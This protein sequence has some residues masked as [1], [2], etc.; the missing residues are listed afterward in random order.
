M[1]SY[2]IIL[3]FRIIEDENVPNVVYWHR[4]MYVKSGTRARGNTHEKQLKIEIKMKWIEINVFAA[5]CLAARTP[6]R[7]FILFALPPTPNNT[8]EI[9]WENMSTW[10]MKNVQRITIK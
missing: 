10:E 5:G 9:I 4:P 1:Y 6:F 7:S 2:A 8:N 3:L